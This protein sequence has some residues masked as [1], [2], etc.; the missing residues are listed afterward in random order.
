VASCASSY[1]RVNNSTSAEP[2]FQAG[3]VV[4][5]F[6][7][8]APDFAAAGGS[9][10]RATALVKRYRISGP[11]LRESLE[12]NPDAVKSPEMAIEFIYALRGAERAKLLSSEE[13]DRT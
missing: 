5:G 12:H 6:I 7:A 3:N 1:G 2:A 8:L 13:A 10:T 9:A 11:M 4:E